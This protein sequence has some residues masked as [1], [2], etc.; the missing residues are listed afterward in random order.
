M[1]IQGGIAYTEYV[2]AAKKR[3]LRNGCKET[4]QPC[5][6]LSR[7]DP[8]TTWI[9]YLSY[10]YLWYETFKKNTE[11]SQQ[12]HDDAWIAL[13]RSEVLEPGER[14]EKL[15]SAD[16][17]ILQEAEE[18][19]AEEDVRVASLKA[20]TLEARKLE[21]RTSRYKSYSRQQQ[22]AAAHTDLTKAKA[23]YDRIKKRNN[24]ISDFI[25]ATKVFRVAS[26]NA[27]YHAKLLH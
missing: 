1:K 3:L 7:Q 15:W 21:P 5:E 27:L 6:D 23:K 20:A 25:Q 11:R 12:Q 26:T 10:E 2:T 18:Q 17:G 16:C 14:E 19:R 4:F 13:L 9:E 8:L 24:G 22:L